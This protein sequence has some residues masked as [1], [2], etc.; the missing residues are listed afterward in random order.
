MMP[1]GMGWGRQR[2]SQ[3]PRSPTVAKI[4]TNGAQGQGGRS[5]VTPCPLVGLREVRTSGSRQDIAPRLHG[6]T[7]NR[8]GSRGSYGTT[9]YAITEPSPNI[10]SILQ[11]QRKFDPRPNFRRRPTSRAWRST[12]RSTRN[13]SSSRRNSGDG[14]PKICTGSRSGTKCWS[15]TRPGPSGLS[16]DRS[17][18]P[19]TVWTGTCKPR[20]RTK[21]R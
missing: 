12:K 10:D 2:G 6:R 1:D 18:F 13:R 5:A 14:P 15:G 21:P 3:E 19:T 11:E 4:L 17:I 9:N 16:E 20:A 8:L 7:E